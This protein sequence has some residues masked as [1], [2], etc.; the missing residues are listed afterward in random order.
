LRISSIVL[1]LSLLS[2]GCANF[3]AVSQFAKDTGDLTRTVRD[4]LA[5]LDE[6]CMRQAEVVIVATGITDD[7]PLKS[8]RRHKAAQGRLAKLSVAV[9][10]DY[11][12]AL[13]GLAND[14]AF[15]VSKEVQGVGREV[16]GLR[17]ADGKALLDRREVS[18]MTKIAELL[19][20]LAASREREAAV[21]RLAA[22]KDNLAVLGG[23]LRSFFVAPPGGGQAPYANLV[24][25]TASEL[26]STQALLRGP[27]MRSAEPIRSFEL[28]REL[29]TRRGLIVRRADPGPEGVAQRTAAAIDLWLAALDRFGDEA[30]SR[31]PKLLHERLKA[32][33]A[34]TDELRTALRVLGT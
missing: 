11:A 6:L 16:T 9:I 2:G 17:D 34:K 4:E 27:A 10:E 13:D 28:V 21:K 8:C 12:K 25:L 7:G 26:D 22:E 31:D 33:R 32:L 15:D 30:L 24:S 14:R 20:Y 19:V 18:A 3:Q 23:L 1:L 5:Q 29:E